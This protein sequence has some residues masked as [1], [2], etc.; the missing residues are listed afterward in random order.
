MVP[1]NMEKEIFCNR[2]V[3]GSSWARET[4]H[5][6]QSEISNSGKFM[7]GTLNECPTTQKKKQI[8]R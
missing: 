8:F 5:S 3:M 1:G 7:I 6:I 2:G 4:D